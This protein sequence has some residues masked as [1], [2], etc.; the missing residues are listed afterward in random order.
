MS[1]LLKPED[2]WYE[3]PE[4]PQQHYFFRSHSLCK[5]FTTIPKT[6]HHDNQPLK[7]CQKCEQVLRK[8]IN[9]ASSIAGKE[10][11]PRQ[12]FALLETLDKIEHNKGMTDKVKYPENV[13]AVITSKDGNKK[14]L[15]SGKKKNKKLNA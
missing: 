15:S 8:L 7:H 14:V 5:Q 12:V 13:T 9:V 4:H 3:V 11:S 6:A 2:G 10:L 1:N